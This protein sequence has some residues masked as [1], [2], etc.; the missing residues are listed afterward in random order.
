[1]ILFLSVVFLRNC[2]LFWIAFR[3]YYYMLH[4]FWNYW[5]S[6]FGQPL[7]KILLSNKK[8]IIIFLNINLLKLHV[9]FIFIIF[10][11]FRFLI[12]Q[13]FT[14]IDHALSYTMRMQY[15]VAPGIEFTLSY[16]ALKGSWLDSQ[17]LKL[18]NQISLDINIF[19]LGWGWSLRFRRFAFRRICL[20][21]CTAWK[22]CLRLR[23]FF[24]CVKLCAWV[25]E[26]VSHLRRLLDSYNFVLSFI[27]WSMYY[28]LRAFIN[29]LDFILCLSFICWW[30]ILDLGISEF[31]SIF[32]C[33]AVFVLY[34]NNTVFCL[35][36]F[37]TFNYYNFWL[38][39]NLK[40]NSSLINFDFNSLNLNRY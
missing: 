25:F 16:E 29:L 31:F 23:Y 9:V 26:C 17:F 34:I 40:A 35:L 8:R 11:Q 30:T 36:F 1:M 4:F 15:R 21:L 18:R 39:I 37:F 14:L 10:Y 32:L 19:L 22:V 3:L 6:N 38:R 2:V 20:W 27:I 5:I 13:S 33:L 12:L 7:M 28:D 24:N